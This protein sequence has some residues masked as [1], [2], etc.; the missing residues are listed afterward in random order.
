MKQKVLLLFAMLSL[1]VTGAWAGVRNATV[2]TN[3]SGQFSYTSGSNFKIY[4]KDGDNRIA[5]KNGINAHT[6]IVVEKLNAERWI[7]KIVFHTKYDTGLQYVVD[8]N[9]SITSG[10][11][12]IESAPNGREKTVTITGINNEEDFM[13][14][15][16]N[17]VPQFDYVQISYYNNKPIELNTRQ[18]LVNLVTDKQGQEAD[19]YHSRQF[20][21]NSAATICLPFD[22]AEYTSGTFYK[23]SEISINPET[24]KFEAVFDENE[25]PNPL[26]ANT[27]YLYMPSE[28]GIA[29]F[30]GTIDE[31]EENVE[32]YDQ[33]EKTA[34]CLYEQVD[35]IT[36]QW[37]MTGT[38]ERFSWNENLG[39]F[40]GFASAFHTG[41]DGTTTDEI[42]FEGTD[43]VAGEFVLAKDGA[44][45][46]EY[47]A[48][49]QLVE[50]AVLSRGA[51]GRTVVAP[52][53]I[54]VRLV[55]K[56]GTVTKLDGKTLT[57]I[58]DSNWYDLQG[59]R[60]SSKPTK[61]GV[62]M[63]NGKKMIVK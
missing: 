33:E 41:S 51:A 55:K 61:A 50:Y 12:V 5:N 38:Y 30:Y 23:L 54:V 35:N 14:V 3:K 45:W 18:Q 25:K 31:V 13:F 1:S 22:I 26:L 46:P 4:Q 48:F 15:C 52:E 43:V 2:N 60:Y 37:E 42:D 11:F 8:N 28:D 6:G 32:T 57:V 36:I 44:Y 34:T 16:Q 27:P 58:N 40:Y 62:Y 39:T 7:T 59:R 47:R 24:E 9:I 17:S 56:N 20:K 53:S 19:V 10:S 63:N 21:Q 29:T 49:L